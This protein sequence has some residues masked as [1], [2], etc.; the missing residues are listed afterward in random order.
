MKRTLRVVRPDEQFHDTYQ[1]TL[2]DIEERL[3]K[4]PPQDRKAEAYSVLRGFCETVLDAGKG[5]IPIDRQVEMKMILSALDRA[6]GADEEK[7]K[8]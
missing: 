6:T 1:R 5:T 3:A 2:R 4:L 7:D 8:K